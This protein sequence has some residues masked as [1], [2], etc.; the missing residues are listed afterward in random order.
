MK[1]LRN[2]LVRIIFVWV[3]IAYAIQ[4]QAGEL[5]A[6][7]TTAL[8]EYNIPTSAVSIFVQDV[9]G[10][11][12]LLVFQEAVP[13]SPA[14]V[15]KLLITF[16]ALDSLG[17]AYTWKTE[18]HASGPIQNGVLSGD[19][20]L[21]GYGDPFLVTE[22]FWKLLQGL[23][24]RGLRHIGG[25]LV[26]D[27]LFFSP[28]PEDRVGF[29]GQSQRAYNAHPDALLVNFQSV[30]FSVIPDQ[31]GRRVRVVVEPMPS[32]LR[33]DN[34]LQLVNGRCRGALAHANM[35]VLQDD[36]DAI[37]RFS[38]KYPLDCG[39]FEMH[40][41]VLPTTSFTFGV[42]KSLWTGMG[43]T[44]EGR[45]RIGETPAAATLLYSIESHA[46]A[47]QIRGL[48]KFSNNVMA[49]QL[50]LTLAAERFGKPGTKSK[51]SAAITD[52]LNTRAL[53]FPE[54]VV[55][56]GSGL[57]RATRISAHN[58]GQLLLSAYKSPYMPE[59]MA[60]LSLAGID[61]TLKNRLKNGPLT[62]RAH[63]KTGQ[64]DGASGVAGYVLTK[65]GN[66]IIVACLLNHPSVHLGA[67]K[68]VQDT[69]LR[70]IHDRY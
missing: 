18:A 54:L 62:G 11:Q 60:S 49:R 39:K 13:R 65:K 44:F 6:A 19:L 50:L 40:R 37:A 61:G 69:L 17:P 4:I 25:D 55:D 14:S 53:S 3:T 45:L 30:L 9:K 31:T 15:I 68:R 16:A 12:P 38:G 64:I 20:I 7:L 59:F 66:T 24:S 46:L 58:L 67:G 23:R 63:L 57:S 41:V 70:W 33:V 10:T 27:N 52:W 48:N 56:N 42:F 2:M 1:S 43:G 35:R 28:G 32:N 8:A 26:I 29:D 47:E 21:K 5:P 22:R 51:G 36:Q 34:R